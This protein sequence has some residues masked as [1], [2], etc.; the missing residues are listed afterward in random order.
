MGENELII[1]D[2]RVRKEK[3]KLFGHRYEAVIPSESERSLR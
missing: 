1:M 3:K 2:D